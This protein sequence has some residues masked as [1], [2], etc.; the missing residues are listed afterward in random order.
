MPSLS[1]CPATIVARR[2]IGEAMRR[3]DG[4]CSARAR[5]IHRGGRVSTRVVVANHPVDEFY[6]RHRL[7]I[8]RGRDVLDERP[9]HDVEKAGY[10]RLREALCLQL[11]EGGTVDQIV[12]LGHR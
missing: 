6:D 7:A 11:V 1:G 4:A 3:D 5:R 9:L 2:S 12:I 8:G 10:F